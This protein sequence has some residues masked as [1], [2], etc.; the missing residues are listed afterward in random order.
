[1]IDKINNEQR[2]RLFLLR[3]KIVSLE[4]PTSSN[5]EIGNYE[6]IR[7]ELLNILNIKGE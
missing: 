5:V 6:W 3:L 2:E 7:Q 4:K 1:M